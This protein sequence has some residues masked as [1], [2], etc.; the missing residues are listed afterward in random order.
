MIINGGK[1]KTG[2]LEQT[3]NLRIQL[4]LLC[5]KVFTPKLVVDIK[6]SL[7]YVQRVPRPFTEM[8]RRH[9]GTKPLKGVEIGFGWGDNTENLLKEL[10]IEKLYCV[11]P[12]LGQSYFIGNVCQ[13]FGNPKKTKYPTLKDNPKLSF[14]RLTS[15]AAFKI[16]P[17]DLDFVYIDGNH[18]YDFVLRDLRNAFDHIH[19]DGFVGGHDFVRGVEDD[20]VPAVFDFALEMRQTPIIKMPDFWFTAKNKQMG[21]RK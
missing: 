15:D 19:P 10:N 5:M 2:L 8:L 9:Y 17:G 21:S 3:E 7:E 14:V 20:V 16:L 13:D 12:Y 18:D 1:V 4:G 11:D 6:E